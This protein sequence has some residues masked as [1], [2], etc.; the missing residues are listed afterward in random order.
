MQHRESMLVRRVGPRLNMNML[1][2]GSRSRSGGVG[3]EC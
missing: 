3:F 2:L 1:V